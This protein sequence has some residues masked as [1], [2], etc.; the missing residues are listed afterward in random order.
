MPASDRRRLLSTLIGS[1]LGFAA[2]A[3]LAVAHAEDFGRAF[4]AAGAGGITLAC[5]IHAPSLLLRLWAFDIAIAATGAPVPRR[6]NW[7]VG[8]IAVLVSALNIVLGA[9]A[10][11]ALWARRSERPPLAAFV[12]ADGTFLALEGVVAM[13]LLVAAS[14]TLPLSPLVPAAIAALVL[15]GLLA[16]WHLGVID[17][18]GDRFPALAGLRSVPPRQLARIA[19][20]I[21]AIFALQIVRLWLCLDLVGI[22]ASP[23]EAVLAFVAVGVFSALPLGAS[24]GPAALLVVFGSAGIGAA[25]A[26]GAVYLASGLLTMA[27]AA[28]I[29][30]LALRGEHVAE[31]T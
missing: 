10:R 2:L 19:L 31:R 17:R 6:T 13:L 7:A 16:A 18:L 11:L 29:G 3:Y 9:A 4:A 23:F 15:C 22:E 1:A 28:A 12:L 30:A 5:A 26:A 25:V 20:L 8:A 24:A 27:V 14:S 21:G